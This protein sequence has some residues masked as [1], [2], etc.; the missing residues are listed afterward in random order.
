MDMFTIQGGKA[1]HGTAVVSGSKNAALPIMAAALAAEG[2]TVLDNVPDLVDV[3]TLSSLLRNLGMQ[4]QSHGSRL[5]L[6]VHD[7][8]PDTAEYDLVRRMRASVCVLGPLLAQ[9]GRACVSLPGGCNIGC[10]PIDLHLKGLA[11]LGAEIDV[12]HGYVHAQA[13]QLRGAR[14]NLSG[15]FGST[16]TG[17]CNVMSAAAL[18]RGTTLI[19]GAAREPEVVALADFLNQMGA[20]ISGQGT[21][22]IVIH[23]VSSLRA[24]H[25]TIIPDRIEAA[26][27][28]IAAAI[29]R[30]SITLTGVRLDHLESVL[31]LLQEIGVQVRF[32]SSQQQS[33]SI[34][35]IS[36]ADNLRPVRFTAVPYP[37]IPT[38]LQAQLIALLCTVPGESHVRDTVFPE[39]FMHVAELRRMGAQIE[40]QLAEARMTGVSRLTGANVMASDL[41]ASAALVLAGLAAAGT[42]TIRRI[43]HLDRGYEQLERKLSQLGATVQRVH[44]EPLSRIAPAA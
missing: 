11:A 27:L 5:E 19:D 16:V 39:R 26:T 22:Q 21:G 3:R 40:Q 29:T 41:R 35:Q 6:E 44:D 25:H 17:T 13:K 10:R 8:R 34:A 1:L 7:D 38:D 30:G 2:R 4:V 9:R 43:Y 33:T 32:I 12:R 14:I 31:D 42:T 15:P 28:M 23:G 24:V 37:G 20:Q 36:V 18:A